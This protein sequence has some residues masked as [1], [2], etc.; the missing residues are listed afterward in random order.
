MRQTHGL[1]FKDKCLFPQKTFETAISNSRTQKDFFY[2]FCILNLKILPYT[3]RETCTKGF[4]KVDH[5][6]WERIF[7]FPCAQ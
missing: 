4:A 7:F 3:T 2:F 1:T 5:R 6:D